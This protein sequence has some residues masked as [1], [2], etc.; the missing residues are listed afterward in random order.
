MCP[1][2]D[3]VTLWIWKSEDIVHMPEYVEQCRNLFPGKPIVMG[4]YLRDYTKVAPVPVE[5]VKRQMEGIADLVEKERLS[6]Y[7]IL[8]SVLIDGHR[9][10]A[11]AVRDF[12][13][14]QSG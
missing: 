2:I 10:Q 13:A 7:S 11:D 14:A 8:A 12:I 9:P 1:H 6:G 5:L 3:V 4:V